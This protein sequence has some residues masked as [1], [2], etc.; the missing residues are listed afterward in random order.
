MYAR[1][2]QLGTSVNVGVIFSCSTGV[3]TTNGVDVR[4]LVQ[5]IHHD[6]CHKFDTTVE[7]Q[8]FVR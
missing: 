3:S 4:W 5:F 7:I 8:F 6:V 1:D 2:E